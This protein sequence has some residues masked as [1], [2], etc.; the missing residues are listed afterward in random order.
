MP[1]PTLVKPSAPVPSMILPENA[2]DVL[3]PPA[4]NVAAVG[5]LFS[6]VPVPASEPIVFEK[7][8][9]SSVALTVKAEVVEKAVADP[10]ASVPPEISVALE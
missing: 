6:T 5:L 1:L 7:P 8:P 4:V 3:L 10:A 9:R 2:V